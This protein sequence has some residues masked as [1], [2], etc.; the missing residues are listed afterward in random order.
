MTVSR[1]TTWP[2]VL[3]V[4]TAVLGGCSDVVVETDISYDDRFAVAKLDV[5]SPPPADALRPAVLVIHGGGW[6]DGLERDGMA[7]HARRLAEAGYVAVNL[8]Y[9]LVPS[10]GE[11]PHAVQDCICALSWIRGHAAAYGIDPDRI[12]AIGYSAGGH[13]VSMLGTAAADPIVAPDCAAGPTTPVAAVVSGAGPQ[14]MGLLLQV[15]N[16]KDF[17]GGSKEEVPERYVQASPISYVSPGAPPFLFIHGD[18]DWFVDLEHARRMGAA[19]EAVGTE[20]RLLEIPGG[21][22]IWNRGASGST[23]DLA[24]AIDLPQ[25]WAATID[26]LDHEIGPV[27]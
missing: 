2:V 8:S 20:H 18:S 15:D 12:G 26:F 10:G 23:W 24:T 6:H 1:T 17:V 16:V 27:P 13:L 7:D 5:Y 4:W 25:A 14:D 9:R 11:F 22:H 3:A 21:G 19:L